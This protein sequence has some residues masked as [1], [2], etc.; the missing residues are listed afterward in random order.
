LTA[1]ETQTQPAAQESA[2][3]STD[4]D[5]RWQRAEL[6]TLLEKLNL[7]H[8]QSKVFAAGELQTLVRN[9][10]ADSARSGRTIDY[11]NWAQLK[12]ALIKA[13][14]L[15]F[16]DPVEPQT[17]PPEASA[18]DAGPAPAA[19]AV[20]PKASF[21]TAPKP[22][23]GT[24]V[25]GHALTARGDQWYV[26]ET[27]Y[28]VIYKEET[29]QF[30]ARTGQPVIHQQ[31]SA[32]SP[33]AWYAEGTN[34]SVQYDTR[35]GTFFTVGKAGQPGGKAPVS[36]QPQGIGGATFYAAGTNGKVYYDG[37]SQLW[38]GVQAGQVVTYNYNGQTRVWA[39]IAGGETYGS[40]SVD[41]TAKLPVVNDEGQELA[42]AAQK[43]QLKCNVEMEQIVTAAPKSGVVKVEIYWPVGLYQ[44]VD[45]IQYA[46]S[47][48]FNVTLIDSKTGAVTDLGTA[49]SCMENL[50]APFT[51][52]YKFS[53]PGDHYT[54][55]LKRLTAE[56]NND[57]NAN[58]ATFKD[59]IWTS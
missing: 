57:K 37:R 49:I 51:R 6:R 2:R 41:Q 43:I 33:A 47:V 48:E 16:D 27:N 19:A 35:T 46:D 40:A 24:Q 14:I 25:D 21:P 36:Y 4:P 29:K 15:W 34:G 9:G 17:A 12:D 42:Q 38:K 28:T 10:I 58:P 50:L 54:L 13:G 39:P 55:R 7:L 26:T 56:G 5:E 59:T 30:V 8:W 31:G 1:G 53:V 11:A 18:P 32:Q 20:A 44:V 45:N 23:P 3:Q 22:A 52:T